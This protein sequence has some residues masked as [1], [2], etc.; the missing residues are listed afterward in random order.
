MNSNGKR[1]LLVAA[2]IVW[3]LVGGCGE[4][5]SVVSLTYDRP[6]KFKI[7][8]KVKR[9][10][11]AEFAGKTRRDERWGVVAADKLCAELA[12]ANREFNRYELVDRRN[13]GKILTEQDIRIMNSEQAV[14]A[15]KLA[16]VQA[17]IYGQVTVNVTDERLSRS[18]FD[19]FSRSMKKK[20]YTKRYCLVA[21]NLTM[22][23]IDTAKTFHTFTL[24]KEFDSDKDKE[25]SSLGGVLGF[26]SDDPPP[27]DQTVNQMLDLVVQQFVR[28]ISPHKVVVSVK[29]GNGK[30]EAVKT[31]NKLAKAGDYAEALEMYQAA[32]SERPDDDGAAFNAGVMYEA[33]CDFSNAEKNY[34][35]AISLKAKD[36]YIEARQRVRAEQ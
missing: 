5:G 4:K 30:S 32:M 19:P 36:E 11:V 27:A 18:Y 31:G 13:L 12:K 15:G 28:E 26:S 21:V 29:L 25:G 2:A 14:K 8:A 3:P 20:D 17:M 16:D 22:D 9:L 34:S 23:D 10:A 33:L 7:P 24:T 1:V 35:K 6:A